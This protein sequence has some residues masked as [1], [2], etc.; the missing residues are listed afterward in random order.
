VRG[1]PG[2]DLLGHESLDAEETHPCLTLL[3]QLLVP[4]PEQLDKAQDAFS[5]FLVL[6]QPLRQ[7]YGL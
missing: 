3:A 7:G 4:S 1:E 2:H 5:Q 6:I